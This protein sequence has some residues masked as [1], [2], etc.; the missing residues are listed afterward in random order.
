ML[1]WEGVAEKFHK[2]WEQISNFLSP[3]VLNHNFGYL[4]AKDSGIKVG[5]MREN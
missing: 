4:W 2:T 3:E 1:N 5:L